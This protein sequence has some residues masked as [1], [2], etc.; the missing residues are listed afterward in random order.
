MNFLTTISVGFKEIWA[1]KF[2]SVL[3]MLG[4]I[5][6]VGS[7]V[8]QSALVKGLENGMKEALI[9]I[10]GLEK[11]YVTP[12]A[13]PIWQQHRKDQAV[14][15]TMNDIY[16]LQR[17]APLVHLVT[18]EMQ[19][20]EVTVTRAGKAFNPWHFVGTWP[21]AL[22]LNQH[23]IEYG[24]M[25]SDVDEKEARSV[26]VIGTGTRDALFGSPE[27]IGREINPVGEFI[28]INHQRFRIIG[29]FQHY[30]SELDRKARA[31]A[32]ENGP[33][34]GKIGPTRKRGQGSGKSKSGA[35]IAFEWK[36]NTIYIPLN[37][38][39]LKFRAGLAAPLLPGAGAA[40]GLDSGPDPRLSTVYFKVN[41]LGQM[42]DA[43][44]QVRN[45]MMHTH[46]GIDD[47]AF[48]TQEN[49]SEN[50]ATATR[51]A[52]LSGGIIAAIS[53]LVGGV[54]IMNI[55]LASITE[56]VR[57]IGVRK[58]I[59][60]TFLDIF[61]QILVESVVIA[62][63]GGVAGLLASQGLVKLLTLVSPADYSPVI[64]LDAMLLAF[65]FSVVVG[66]LAGIFPGLKAARLHPIQAL[67]Y[68]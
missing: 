27:E 45:V 68:E 18:P 24:R 52:R 3:T 40:A 31:L 36:N 49:W 46:K 30:E 22:E 9:A 61:I 44:Q 29:M 14:G 47:F 26:C 10:G 37:T 67:R 57:E 34:L 66:V 17:S 55:M 48:N 65:G 23:V 21:G 12:Q 64:T 39:W 7:L 6:G 53:L 50:I 11:V 32:R 2:R 1:N 60:A 28:N 56:R 13:I 54:G 58:A 20:R 35:G 8:A 63:I 15:N 51:N 62:V 19:T 59:G 4:I 42:N 33:E 16:A 43:L 5:L 41:D 38:M 25:V